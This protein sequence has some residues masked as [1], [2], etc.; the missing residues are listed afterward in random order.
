MLQFSGGDMM[1]SNRLSVLLATRKLKATRVSSDTGI[2]RSTLASLTGEDSKMIQFETI[3]KLCQYLNIDPGEF[4]L[5]T[6][7]S[8]TFDIV[9]TAVSTSYSVS[10]NLEWGFS[11]MEYKADVFAKFKRRGEDAKIIELSANLEESKTYNGVEEHAFN[12]ENNIDIE[13]NSKDNEFQDYWT[14]LKL[15]PFYSVVESSFEAQLGASVINSLNEDAGKDV[16]NDWN[17][18]TFL[19]LLPF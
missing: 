18:N 8:L 2:A 16:F 1:I 10:E 17:V 14:T 7:Y 6:P 11:V 3:D 15:Q 19:P 13:I 12:D 9:P 5:Y 4:F